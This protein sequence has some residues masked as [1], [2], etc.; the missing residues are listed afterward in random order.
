MRKNRERRDLSL[1]QATSLTYLKMSRRCWHHMCRVHSINRLNSL[2]ISSSPREFS[3]LQRNL[4]NRSWADSTQFQ[5]SSDL[6]ITTSLTMASATNI[7]LSVALAANTEP[8]CG[9]ITARLQV[10]SQLR[11]LSTVLLTEETCT[12]KSPSMLLIKLLPIDY[13]SLLQPYL[14]DVWDT[15]YTC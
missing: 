9:S 1:R 7:A 3:Q 13:A 8:M 5:I 2:K 10:V 11:L 14:F 15:Y 6:S 12:D 4:K